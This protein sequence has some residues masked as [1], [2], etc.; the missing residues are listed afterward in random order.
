MHSR[1]ATYRLQLHEGFDFDAA[2][3]VLEYLRDLGITHIYC[4]PVLQAAP[5]SKHG[6]D[7]VDY[8]RVSEELGGEQA[9]ARFLRKLEET[10]LG[11]VL[12]IVPN[13]MAITGS[14]NAW[15]WDTLENGTLSR[16]APYFDIEWNTPEERLRNKILPPVLDDHSGRVIGAG[17]LK[18]E[19]C[20]GGFVLHYQDPYISGGARVDGG[21]IEGRGGTGR[22]PATRFSGRRAGAFAR[23]EG[24]R[25]VDVLVRA[26]PQQGS[27]PR[28]S[29][30]ALLGACGDRGGNR[31]G[32]GKNERQPGPHGQS[33]DAATLPASEHSCA[34]ILVLKAAVNH[35][36]QK[37]CLL[38]FL[39]YR[40][41]PI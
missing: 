36:I 1:L 29:G 25:R 4:S 14:R 30:E 35:R 38:F 8:H 6:Y 2:C 39:F 3:G 34:V 33:S 18:L 10:G 23:G 13:H 26:S 40:V 19:R 9:R 11:Q 37:K 16:Y 21:C 31:G 28:A 7:V 17:K 5:G 12:D 24:G 41:E 22:Q 15:W 32:S 27:D 20:G